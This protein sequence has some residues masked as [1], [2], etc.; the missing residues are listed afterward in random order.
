MLPTLLASTAPI[1]SNAARAS[2]ALKAPPRRVL[3]PGH[4]ML[5]VF[6]RGPKTGD[7]VARSRRCALSR[8]RPE[9]LRQGD[10]L[11]YV[12]S[13]AN[14]KNFSGRHRALKRRTQATITPVERLANLMC[15]AHE[16]TPR[17]CCARQ[18][19]GSAVR[20]TTERMSATTSRRRALAQRNCDV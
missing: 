10:Y 6:S 11:A 1:G 19:R 15:N 2:V 12:A 9:T 13:C 8:G 16:L 3:Q 4:A 7:P 17:Q 18:A 14:T 20:P 5:E